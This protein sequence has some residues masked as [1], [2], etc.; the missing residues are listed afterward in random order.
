METAPCDACNRRSI[1]IVVGLPHL[2]RGPLLDR[3]KAKAYPALISANAFS[4]WDRRSG[5]PIWKGWDL[6]SLAHADGLVS[7][8]LDSA[9][10][11]LASR[12]RGIPWSTDAYVALATSHPFRRWA[13]LDH[14][15]EPEI[16]RDRDEVLDRIARTIALNHACH[17]RGLERGIADRFMPVVQGRSAH[18][19]LRSLDGI[20]GLIRPGMIIGVGSMCR[21]PIHGPEGLL[22]VVS[23][24][25]RSL[26]TTVMLHLFGV[27]GTALGHLA[28]LSDR[29]ASI[30]SAAY[31]IAARREAYKNRHTKSDRFVAEH[32]ERWAA[33]Q[34]KRLETGAGAFQ[35]Q[36]PLEAPLRQI[37]RWEASLAQAREEIREL[38]AQ[39]DIDHD[40][41]PDPWVQQW[42]AEIYNATS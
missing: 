17:A 25:D 20:A 36:L 18:D 30:D 1:E 6:R 32:M 34:A 16:A 41:M 31:G 33:I 39:G 28:P 10:F 26:P 12:N 40:G 4:Q 8:D 7:L 38:I 23:M 14:C 9:G 5:Y 29:V 3:A 42:A 24:L 2:R 13:S 19:Y 15:V 37:S 35:H 11:V 21:R 22:E 27:K